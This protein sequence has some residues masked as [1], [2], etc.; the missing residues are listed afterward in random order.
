M[1]ATMSEARGIW[2]GDALW[3]RIGDEEVS[4]K[5]LRTWVWHNVPGVMRYVDVIRKCHVDAYAARKR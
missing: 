4:D 1:G 5:D 2:R 3:W